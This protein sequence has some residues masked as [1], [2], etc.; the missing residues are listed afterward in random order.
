MPTIRATVTTAD[1]TPKR[2]CPAASTA[3]VDRGVTVRPNPSPNAGERERDLF[4]RRLG[5]PCGH[6][7]QPADREGESDDRHEAQAGQADEE[8]RNEGADRGRAGQRPEGESLLDP[9][10]RTA[11]DRRT[12]PPR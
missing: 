10:R 4:D 9:V 12:R 5:R 3:A 6:R 1:A 2:C 11:R 7:Q 8:A